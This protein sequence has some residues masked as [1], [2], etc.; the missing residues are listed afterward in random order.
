MA[1]AKPPQAKGSPTTRSAGGAA[2]VAAGILVSRIFGLFRSRL[3][4]H[5]LGVGDAADALTQAIKIPN[6]LQNLFGE[7]GRAH[8]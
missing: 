6:V 2:L 4:G 1:E 3:I 7:I 5:F 8:V